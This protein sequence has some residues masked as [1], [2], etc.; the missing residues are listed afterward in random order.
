VKCWR[1]KKYPYNAY[2]DLTEE[3]WERFVTK[4]K[5]E[6]LVMNNQYM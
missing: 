2:K 3:D 4:Y 6:D 5:S 1:N